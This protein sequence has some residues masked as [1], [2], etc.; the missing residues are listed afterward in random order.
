MMDFLAS[1]L[2]GIVL[3]LI[4]WRAS[5]D[6]P[7]EHIRSQWKRPYGIILRLSLVILILHWIF[8]VFGV[9]VAFGYL[10]LIVLTLMCLVPSSGP[11]GVGTI[12]LGWLIY[13]WALWFPSRK[14]VIH[15]QTSAPPPST[16]NLNGKTGH[17]I[18]QLSPVGKVKTDN[19]EIM[20]RAEYGS[21]DAGSAVIIT[22]KNG[23]EYLVR[24]AE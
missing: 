9:S 12:V 4:I 8:G 3:I 11:V 23:F 17:A 18:T 19:L 5:R 16:P 21:I 2:A 10:T 7:D 13:E 6:Y 22:G 1:I 24:K 14:T 20:A 15:S